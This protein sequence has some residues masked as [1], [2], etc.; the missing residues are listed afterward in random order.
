MTSTV[1]RI[2]NILRTFSPDVPPFIKTNNISRDLIAICVFE[3]LNLM[4][5]INIG[6][7]SSSSSTK[8]PTQ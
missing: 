8:K 5:N 2:F 1:Q 3:S 6:L 7:A 4:R